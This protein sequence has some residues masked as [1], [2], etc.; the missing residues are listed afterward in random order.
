MVRVAPEFTV[1]VPGVVPAVISSAVPRE[2]VALVLRVRSFNILEPDVKLSVDPVPV[3]I[4][5]EV[6]EPVMV[7]LPVIE[8]ALG[9]H[10]DR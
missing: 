2:A 5:L 7:P 8:P 10:R 6:D 4:R 3:M 9:L 1:T